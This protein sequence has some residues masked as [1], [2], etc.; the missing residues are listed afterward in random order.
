MN[1]EIGFIHKYIVN[2]GYAIYEIEEKII[3]V[4]HL[5]GLSA[6]TYF[7][8]DWTPNEDILN[9]YCDKMIQTLKTCNSTHTHSISIETYSESEWGHHLFRTTN[10]HT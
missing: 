1:I 7:N 5:I 9:R 10:V 3:G 8:S 6:T 2:N 4:F